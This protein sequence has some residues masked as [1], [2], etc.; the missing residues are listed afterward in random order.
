MR[1]VMQGKVSVVAFGA[2]GAPY[3]LNPAARNATRLFLNIETTFAFFA[4]LAAKI[5]PAP[6]VQQRARR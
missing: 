5:T 6:P 1:T 4:L 2:H 3:H